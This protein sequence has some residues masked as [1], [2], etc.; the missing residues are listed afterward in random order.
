MNTKQNEKNIVLGHVKPAER[1]SQQTV[2]YIVNLLYLAYYKFKLA[3]SLR[4][5]EVK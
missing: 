2:V 5:E 1:S 4:Q 3:K